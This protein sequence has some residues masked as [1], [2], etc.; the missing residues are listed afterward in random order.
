MPR[1]PRA[2]HGWPARLVEMRARVLL[3][4]PG[5]VAVLAVA[6]VKAARVLELT[7]GIPGQARVARF[8][9]TE[10]QTAQPAELEVRIEADLVEQAGAAWR[11]DPVLDVAERF[12][13]ADDRELEDLRP[14]ADSS[15]AP[16]ARRLC[17]L[18]R[19]P[20]GVAGGL[21]EPPGEA[22]V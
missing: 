6:V 12:A 10:G 7:G 5:T 22:D 3:I 19:V 9:L 14:P 13:L 11:A 18:D 1:L 20:P 15:G 17:V 16:A 8:E 21:V 2:W 4:S